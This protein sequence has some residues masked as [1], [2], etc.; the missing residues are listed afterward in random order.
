MRMSDWS[1][2]VCSSDLEPGPRGKAQ[3]KRQRDI[4]AD[5]HAMVAY[6]IQ[7]PARSAAGAGGAGDHPVEAVRHQPAERK[8]QACRSPERVL[9]VKIG[10]GG[11]KP[12]QQPPDRP[13]IARNAKPPPPPPPTPH[14][15]LDN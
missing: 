1:S 14:K 4:D 13:P 5:E 15:R 2:D 6:A 12:P 7:H 11:G 9:P 3:R 8:Q 10:A